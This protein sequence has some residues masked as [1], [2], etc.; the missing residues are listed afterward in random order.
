MMLYFR[1]DLF[2]TANGVVLVV[3]VFD[4]LPIEC[5][6]IVDTFPHLSNNIFN[7][8]TGHTLP[9]EFNTDLGD[10]E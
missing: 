4:D 3:L 5:F 6:T 10:Q 1:Y 2:L 7:P 8:S 9:R